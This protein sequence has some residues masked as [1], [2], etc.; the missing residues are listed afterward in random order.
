MTALAPYEAKAKPLC[1]LT[2]DFSVA[3]PDTAN[4][5]DMEDGAA[6]SIPKSRKN[7][8][9]EFNALKYIMERRYRN[10]GDQFTKRWN[11]HL[12]LEF[13]AGVFQELKGKDRRL[14]P[15]TTAH[16]RIGKQFNRLHTARLTFGA[17]FGYYEGSKYT[18]SQLA[19]SADWLFDLSS[20]ICGY[21]PSRLLDVS[22]VIGAGIRYNNM[23]GHQPTRHR[24]EFHGGVQMRFFT[25]PQGYLSFEPYIGVSSRMMENKYGGFYGANLSVVYYLNNNLSIEERMRYMKNRPAVAD[26]L[27][28]PAPWRTPWFAEVAGGLS[29]FHGSGNSGSA[30]LGHATALS[31]GRWFSPLVGVRIGGSLNSATW[32]QDEVEGVEKKLNRHNINADARAEILINPFGFTSNYNW[33]RPIGMSIALGGGLSWLMKNQEKSLHTTSTF[34]SAGLHL[35]TRLTDDLQFFIEPRYTNYNYKIPYTNAYGV[36]RFSDDVYTL[37]IGLTAYT[38]GISYRHKAPEYVAPAVP[39]S[40]GV[41]A[42][43]SLLF[44]HNSYEGTKMNYNFNAFAEGHITRI[45]GVRL[46]FEYMNING[47]KPI[48]YTSYDINDMKYVTADMY[49]HSHMR[50]FLSLDYLLNVTNLFSG[51]Q[52]RRL[53]EAEMFAG[54]TIMFAMNSTSKLV[55]STAKPEQ[56]RETPGKK[57][58]DK[59]LMGANGGIKL[60]CNVMRHLALTLTPQIHVLRWDPQLQGV[61]ILKFRAFETLDFGVQYDL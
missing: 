35:W 19:T 60:K 53:F 40:F 26:S 24:Y 7:L 56:Q 17:G 50:G 20:Y 29:L 55:G 14:S 27:L 48:F 45:H 23:S 51:Y 8:A 57:Y 59:P 21:K 46:A 52:G 2:P 34:Y 1:T 41:G 32:M 18:Y 28:K 61:D 3:E 15:I 47:L 36:K 12:F 5:D 25:G 10:Y 4:Y 16:V 30:K 22:S 37:N 9:T 49:E 31:L 44:R 13:G 38:R 11:D 33:N 43:T 42:G 58:Y 54:P 6:D 39:L